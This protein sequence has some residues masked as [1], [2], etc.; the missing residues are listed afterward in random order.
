MG[1]RE[2][3]GLLLDQNGRQ[4][5]PATLT[6]PSPSRTLAG[7]HQA[8]PEGHRRTAWRFSARFSRHPAPSSPEGTQASLCRHR[9]EALD[10]TP[11][12]NNTVLSLLYILRHS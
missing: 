10:H 3:Y 5:G 8:R 7:R 2:A 9:A 11:P 1:S 12:Y 4:P 6:G